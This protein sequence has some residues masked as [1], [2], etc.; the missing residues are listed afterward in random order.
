MKIRKIAVIHEI[1]VQVTE[2]WYD[3]AHGY[4]QR[5]KELD[6]VIWYDWTKLPWWAY[7]YLN[8]T[9][10][11][12]RFVYYEVLKSD[13]RQRGL[14]RRQALRALQR[15]KLLPPRLEHV[16]ALASQTIT[17]Q[18]V[19]KFCVR[20]PLDPLVVVCPTSF[21]PEYPDFYWFGAHQKVFGSRDYVGCFRR[22][23]YRRVRNEGGLYFGEYAYHTLDSPPVMRNVEHHYPVI[24]GIVPS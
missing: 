7:T 3:I 10:F 21:N 22:T 24:M 18:E 15:M 12:A 8:P 23:C 1:P 20:E 4:Q 19:C 2:Q 13:P 17:S 11:T 5:R 16:A 6:D 9:N 14:D